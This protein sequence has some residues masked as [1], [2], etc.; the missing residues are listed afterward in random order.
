VFEHGGVRKGRL[1]KRKRGPQGPFSCWRARISRV[2][3]HDAQQRQQ[4]LEHVEQ[5][6]V[7]RQRGGDVVGLAAV[8]DLLQVVQHVSRLKM[9]MASTLIT[10]MPVRGADEHVD[11]GAD[12]QGQGADEQPLAECRTGRA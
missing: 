1:N 7:Q 6:Q 8:D 5:V 3:A 10:S 12:H 2:A 4:A 9:P 11:D